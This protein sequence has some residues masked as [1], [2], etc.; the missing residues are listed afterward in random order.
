MP[1]KPRVLICGSRYYTDFDTVLHFVQTLPGGTVIIEGEAKGADKL[2]RYAAEMCDYSNEQILRFPADWKTYHKA[3]GPI[4][5]QQMLAEGKPTH[6]V[7]FH[8]DLFGS[9]GTYHMCSIAVKLGLPVTVNT[10]TW[11]DVEEGI[12]NISLQD[13]KAKK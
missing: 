3:A 12:G 9:K 2:S 6:V 13:L 4:R 5:N 10:G 8:E 1:S 7:A 11:E